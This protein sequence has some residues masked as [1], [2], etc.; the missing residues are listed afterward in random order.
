MNYNQINEELDKLEINDLKTAI[1]GNL[2]TRLEDKLSDLDEDKTY[3]V[4]FKYDNDLDTA[5][6]VLEQKIDELIE[7]YE[8]KC[9]DLLEKQKMKNKDY[10]R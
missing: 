1:K 4:N 7:E 10:E 8:E 2:L 5:I 6:Y 3:T 9:I